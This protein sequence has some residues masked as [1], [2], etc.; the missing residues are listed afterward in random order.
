MSL[1]LVRNLA[2]FGQYVVERIPSQISGTAEV[3]EGIAYGVY[4]NNYIVKGRS[5]AEAFQS[6]VR[7]PLESWCLNQTPTEPVIL[8]V[9]ALDEALRL[10]RHPNIVDLIKTA[11]DLPN[12][13][14]WLLTSRPGDH[15][16]ALPGPCVEILDASDENQNDV[17]AYV[18][19]FLEE[20]LISQAI[21]EDGKD[22]NA[23]CEELVEH[24]SGNF[25]YLHYI[26]SSIR[27]N[28][29]AGRPLVTSDRLPSGLV[30]IYGEFLERILLEKAPDE[31][32][33]L[34][35]PVL[36]TLA[37]AREG[38]PFDLLVSLS[39]IT[40]QDLNDVL[41]DL[42]QFLDLDRGENSD[43]YR[44]Y[45]TSFADFLTDRAQNPARWIEAASQ[46]NRIVAYF[47]QAWGG[48]D[49]G[50]P[51]LNASTTRGPKDDYGLRYLP[52]HLEGA[53]RS[54]DL[55]R[56]LELDR[57]WDGERQNLWY[58][59]KART[60]QLD[61]YQKD[62]D[63]AWANAKLSGDIALQIRYAL[64]L[65]SVRNV[66]YIPMRLLET[67]LKY[68]VFTSQQALDFAQLYREPN[69][70]AKALSRLIPLLQ[71]V[72][73]AEAMRNAYELAIANLNSEV[74]IALVPHLPEQLLLE[75]LD[76][77]EDIME[78]GDAAKVLSALAAHLPEED[79]ETAREIAAT[80]VDDLLLVRVLC[81][82]AAR[83]SGAKRNEALS[84]IEAIVAAMPDGSDKVQALAEVAAC[85]EADR[86]AK[87]LAGALLFARELE[88][89]DDLA[90]ALGA[91]A[92]RDLTTQQIDLALEIATKTYEDE[93][94]P[95]TLESYASVLSVFGPLLSE[96]QRADVVGG[97]V[98][99][100]VKNDSWITSSFFN[101]LIA[102]LSPYVSQE[103]RMELF[104][105][106]VGHLIWAVTGAP[107][108]I[109]PERVSTRD[110][111][112]HAALKVLSTLP[113]DLLETAVSRAN[114]VPHDADRAEILS[115]LV[116]RL[117]PDR[118]NELLRADVKRVQALG[119]EA[120]RTHALAALVAHMPDNQRAELAEITLRAAE[121]L[122]YTRFQAI[123]K[124]A[125]H[126]SDDNRQKAIQDALIAVAE[127]TDSRRR[128][129][130]LVTLS[131]ILSDDSL[132]KALEIAKGLDSTNYRGLAAL[133]PSLPSD[134]RHD[135]I[136]KVLSS[137]QG[138][139][140]VELPDDF[141]E[142]LRAIAP[143]LDE[144]QRTIAFETCKALLG[145]HAE[146]LAVLAPWLDKKQIDGAL[147]AFRRLPRS[148]RSDHSARVLA[149]LPIR[150]TGDEQLTEAQRVE[151][152]SESLT[153]AREIEAD[154][155][156]AKTLAA[157]L[158]TLP[159]DLWHEALN[160]MLSSCVGTTLVSDGFVRTEKSIK[161]A[162]LLAQI[163]ETADTIAEVGG[164]RAIMDTVRAIRDTAAWWP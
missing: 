143:Y 164:E 78:D 127:L 124:L 135:L 137:A 30:G 152:L 41:N 67:A 147:K 91:L 107:A 15:I 39:S 155:Y 7:E 131:P 1:Q 163:A 58:A 18:N 82:V 21:R 24:S 42:K 129:E 52:A 5:A 95:G 128:S 22:Q 40:S 102:I 75:V 85:Q 25:L 98:T 111:K 92:G 96:T 60:G 33:S 161:R 8:L 93:D 126:L 17:R 116:P 84:E 11:R 70:R 118:S 28:A 26:F 106:V 54:Q 72:E 89:A 105:G 112:R 140:A 76:A 43:Y 46:H 61:R 146:A 44:I 157:L 132:L 14:H 121:K 56:L 64:C 77:T 113:E 115:V 88:Y 144:A 63:R 156:R 9:D 3:G 10:D 83:R 29:T 142:A 71:G 158:P 27:E 74:L 50:L 49:E 148:R 31:W 101:R 108:E 37:V 139:V 53:N 81:A 159:K 6:L 35:R 162:F 2:D 103:Q 48:L 160:E 130:A 97:L 134:Q 149:E 145:N 87:T 125:P 38:L 110:W 13:I 151:A 69:E 122:T 109:F 120:A 47:L 86:S 99:K 73:R 65:S 100:L 55:H 68:D 94:H 36:G 123:A 117:A 153:R 104:P 4:I 23:F 141:V 80:I 90:P 51:K 66:G 79:L 138:W 16:R 62:I 12:Q 136:D 119:D 59:V 45:H 32:K 133:I 154:D 34:Y 57:G 20:P 150:L 114:E 19:D